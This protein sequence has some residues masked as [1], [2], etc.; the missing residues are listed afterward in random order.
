METD[1]KE[2]GSSET[3]QTK[4]GVAID[5]KSKG[6]ESGAWQG[7]NGGNACVSEP[8]RVTTGQV[9]TE[10][11]GSAIDDRSKDFEVFDHPKA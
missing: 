5:D 9:T 11:G 1:N 10:R 6:A 2:Q 3:I 4:N 7:S 8:D